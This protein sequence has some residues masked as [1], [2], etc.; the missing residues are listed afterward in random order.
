MSSAIPLSALSAAPAPSSSST[1]P[2]LRHNILFILIDGIGDVTL[3]SLANSAHPLGRTPMQAASLPTLDKLARHGLTGLMDSVEAG[4]ACGSDTAH[5]SLLGYDPLIYYRGR[6]AF[7][8]M[9]AGLSME[10]GDIAFKSNF[11]TIDPSSGIVVKRRA[12]RRFH[13]WGV[14]LCQALDGARLP[15]FPEITVSVRYATEHRCGVRLRGPGLTDCISGTDPLVDGRML[16]QCVPSERTEAAKRTADVVNEVSNVFRSILASHPINIDRANRNLPIANVVL[17]RGA[18]A[19]IQVPPFSAH[20]LGRGCMVAPTAIIAG[21]GASVGLE[22]L[23]C[24]E[25]TGDYRTNLK[26]KARVILQAMRNSTQHSGVVSSSASS[27]SSPTPSSSPALSPSP[28][29][30]YEFGFLHIKAVDDAGHDR[31]AR[32]KIEWLE[33]SD[34]MISWILDELRHGS[35]GTEDTIWSIVVTGDHSTP[36]AYGDHA[37]EPVPFIVNTLQL[38][39]GFEPSADQS[40]ASLLDHP[41]ITALR[42]LVNTSPPTVRGFDEIECAN[43]S[44][45]RFPGREVI[46][47]LKRFKAMYRTQAHQSIHHPIYNSTTQHVQAPQSQSPSQSASHQLQLHPVG[48]PTV[49][50]N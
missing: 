28:S 30:P 40:I 1:H 8:S 41:D 9:G 48:T 24:Q 5:L 11:A 50:S 6:G 29:S 26:A 23:P 27:Q 15:N 42:Q 39:H 34:E 36:V 2:Q 7:E 10:V 38:M 35:G 45:G 12:D 21:L 44:L 14:D 46:P 4:Q 33:R 18:G 19:R 25:A 31:D 13:E 37:C 16:R 49:D 3:K 20:G 47:L 43:G 22:L 32:R 17:L